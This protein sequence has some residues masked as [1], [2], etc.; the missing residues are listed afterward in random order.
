MVFHHEFDA[1]GFDVAEGEE[2]IAPLDGRHGGVAD[3]DGALFHG[4]GRGNADERFS[5][6]MMEFHNCA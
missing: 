1:V 6:A 5:L 3:D 2:G 4:G